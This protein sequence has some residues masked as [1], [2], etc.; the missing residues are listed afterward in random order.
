MA[1]QSRWTTQPASPASSTNATTSM[2][3]TE[4]ESTRRVYVARGLN[5]PS[6]AGPPDRGRQHAPCSPRPAAVAASSNR[7]RYAACATCGR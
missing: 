5:R 7:D 6:S 1:V 3:T 2:A 4:A